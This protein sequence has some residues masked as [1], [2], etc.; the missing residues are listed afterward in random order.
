MELST[1]KVT[2]VD[3]S[4][5][6]DIVA[7]RCDFGAWLAQLPRRNRRIAESLAIGNKCIGCAGEVHDEGFIELQS[8]VTVDYHGNG[9]GCL[10]RIE[11]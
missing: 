7:F 1:T 4:L 5:V 2:L 9:F 3:Y 6:P 10:A 11:G 8:I